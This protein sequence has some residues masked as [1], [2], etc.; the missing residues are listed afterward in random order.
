MDNALRLG[1]EKV[2]KL[3]VRFSGPAIIGMLINGLYNVV[4]RIF[5]GNG[6]GFLGIAGITIA[7]PIMIIIMACAMLIGMGANSLISIRLGEQKKEE[8]ELI[9]GNAMVL[10][11]TI[12]IVVSGLGLLFI[13]P[14]LKLF[15][16]S[17]AILPYAKEYLQVILW[18]TVFQSIGFGMNSFIRAEGNP[19]IAMNTMLIGAILNIIL[20]PIFI[21]VFKWGIRGAALATVISQAASAIWVLYHFFG[22]RSVLKIYVKNL[23]LHRSTVIKIITLGLAPFSMQLVSSVLSVIMN[24]SLNTYGGDV[25]ISGMGIVTSI[26]T[27]LLLPIYGINQGAQPIIGYNYGAGKFDRVKET[28]K[29]AVLA[30][31]CIVTF[32]YILIRVFP[33]QLITLFNKE[34]VEM[35][36]FGTRAL[37]IYLMLLPI[38]GFQMV[39]S[40]YFQA[41]GKPKQSAILSL[42]R[43]CLILIPALLILPRIFKLDGVLMAGP[44]A[45][46]LSTIMTGIWLSFEFKNLS[47]QKLIQN[48]FVLDKSKEILLK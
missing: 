7:F 26:M 46:G 31:T 3:L 39:G 6:V 16:S 37:K 21:F 1:E 41:V 30:A 29:L 9:V 14:L 5:I 25:S 34:E 38:V 36:A 33:L 40:N 28:L 32:G 4:D 8:A 18:G 23:K 2:S 19:K 17:E 24:R 44:L 22:G 10:L 13:N 20:D 12:S 43:Q 11:I 42:S 15:G 45:D 27:L 47:K 48:G 35:I